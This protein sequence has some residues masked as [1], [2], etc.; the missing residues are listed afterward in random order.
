MT[1]SSRL[2][3][4]FSAQNLP[5]SRHLKFNV[6]KSLCTISEPTPYPNPELTGKEITQYWFSTHTL[7]A[8]A[9]IY[10]IWYKEI[11]GKSIK[12][13]PDSIGSILTPIGLAHWIQGD[14]YWFFLTSYRAISGILL[15]LK[16]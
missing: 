3:F 7:P 12:I 8:L 16:L 1:N 10:N 9:Q 5:Y 4:T 13:L 15:R 11:D 14:G 2:E 6:Y